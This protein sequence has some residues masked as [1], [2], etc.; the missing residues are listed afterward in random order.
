MGFGLPRQKKRGLG[1]KFLSTLNKA[2]LYKWSW[3]FA[4]EKGAFWNQ[5]IRG[6][7]G[8]SKGVGVP[9]K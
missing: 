8:E 4:N 3:R 7:F 9:R 1:V 5:V 6:K 2:L